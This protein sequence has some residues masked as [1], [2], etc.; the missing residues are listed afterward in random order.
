[1]AEDG[2]EVKRKKEQEARAKEKKLQGR[3]KGM[4]SFLAKKPAAK[5]PAA[6]EWTPYLSYSHP[7]GTRTL[8]PLPLSTSRP[9]SSDHAG[10]FLP[11]A[12]PPRTTIAPI[13][14]CAPS[15]SD[16]FAPPATPYV[17][18]V[19]IFLLLTRVARSHS[20][21]SWKKSWHEKRWRK[22]RPRGWMNAFPGADARSLSGMEQRL[23]PLTLHTISQHTTPPFID[24]SH[25]LLYQR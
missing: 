15:S 7:N 1:M 5:A 10:L 3:Q 17:L 18:I 12:R 8:H 9:R 4:M 20:L 19:A 25:G 24:V 6:D 14:R 16:P 21:D 13:V 22:R 23:P 11:M 2:A